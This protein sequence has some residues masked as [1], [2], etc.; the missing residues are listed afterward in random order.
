MP[1]ALRPQAIVHWAVYGTSGHSFDYLP[2]MYE[3]T[4]YYTLADDVKRH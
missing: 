1:F 3:L 4:A 2:N